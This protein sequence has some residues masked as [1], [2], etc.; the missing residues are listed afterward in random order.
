MKRKICFINGPNL[1]MLGVREPKIYGEKSLAAIEEEIQSLAHKQGVEIDFFQS[2]HEGKIID[3]I[4]E[5]KGRFDCILINAGA[6]SHYSI[7]IYDA[8]KAVEIP[9][10][11]IHL[12]NIYARESFRQ[13]SLISPLVLGG[14]F[15]F[16][17]LSYKMAFLAACELLYA[18]K[19]ESHLGK[20]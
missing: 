20:G 4:Q 5:S 13:Q 15:G 2:N 7:A 19:K 12:S 1:N 14:V 6:F 8:L 17:S 9:V 10:I 3:Y 11:E 16:G 18:G